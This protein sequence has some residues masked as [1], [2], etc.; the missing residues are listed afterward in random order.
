[1]M[2]A[3]LALLGLILCPVM[4]VGLYVLIKPTIY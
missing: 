3:L 2:E 4:A 1:M